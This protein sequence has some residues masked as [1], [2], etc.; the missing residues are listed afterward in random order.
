MNHLIVD[1]HIDIAYNALALKRDLRR[2]MAEIR[3]QEAKTPPPGRPPGTCLVNIAELQ[4]G[5]IAV[6]GA[7]I[8]IE[9]AFRDW[10]HSAQVYHTT[11]EAH[12]LAV[13]QLD[14]Y[15]KLDET[16]DQIRLLA[17]TDDLETVLKTWSTEEPQT[18]LFIIMEGAEGIREPQE[19][20]WWV[21]RGLRGVGLTWSAGTR[22]AG[23]NAA[24]GP[25]SS[26]GKQL[27][28]VMAEYNLL[29]DLSHMWSDAAYEALDR[30]PGPIVATHANPR[31][32]VNTP[33]M[34][35]DDLIHRIADRDGVIGVIP[36]NVMLQANW[37]RGDERLPLSRLVEAID[38]ICQVSGRVDVIGIGSDFDGGFGVESVPQGLDSSADLPKI[39]D[40]LLS[41]GYSDNDIDAILS[42]NWLRM[43][44][45]T[46]ASMS[47][48]S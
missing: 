4:A 32:F 1:A 47:G 30:Y 20:A 26:E 10:Q 5:K 27:L 13:T 16:H 46:L 43:M 42:G 12:D 18:G 9:P 3:A 14:Y 48:V 28:D 19:L 15:R 36:F 40:E 39:A 2:P 34:L 33:R 24:P 25:L 38:H 44:R 35:S 41:R 17:Q 31:A 21:E 29:L 11:A 45:K 23:G 37:H 6:A 7:S 8:F 22:Y